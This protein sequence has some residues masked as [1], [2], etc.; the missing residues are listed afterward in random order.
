MKALSPKSKAVVSSDDELLILVD[1]D[2]A[3]VGQMAK[4]KCHLNDGVLHRAFSIFIFNKAGE[5]LLQQRSNQKLLWPRYWSNACCSH[6]RAGETMEDAV[7]RRLY[8]ELGVRTHL[9]YLY[10]F[11]YRA[12]YKDIG[13]EHESCWVW[14]G[15]A[16]ADEIRENRN[17]IE[18]WRF[19]S[20]GE[21]NEELH[22]HPGRF[23]PWMKMEYKKIMR[24]FTEK[25]PGLNKG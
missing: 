14:V 24:E 22:N 4:L 16:E 1:K 13:T 25:I 9:T 3:A 23:T 7:H 15:Q 6:P 10:K 11:V 17:E 18:S 8:E 19:I 21:L 2:D 12:K 20:I 5:I